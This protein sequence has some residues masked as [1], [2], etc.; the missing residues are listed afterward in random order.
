MQPFE[1]ALRSPG[2]RGEGFSQQHASSLALTALLLGCLGGDQHPIPC[3]QGCERS[4]GKVHLSPGI[5]HD[6]EVVSRL[7]PGRMEPAEVREKSLLV[8]VGFGSALEQPAEM[9][10]SETSPEWHGLSAGM[11]GTPRAGLPSHQG[12]NPVQPKYLLNI[13]HPIT[14]KLG[15]CQ[16]K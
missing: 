2:Y 9:P 6:E 13:S 16:A 8:P 4:L 3:V 11:E 5:N 1:P 7:L 12:A 10:S 15:Q 14:I